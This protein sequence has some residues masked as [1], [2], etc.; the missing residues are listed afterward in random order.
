MDYFKSIRPY[1]DSEVSE[2]LDQF[3]THDLMQAM[4]LY[5][6]PELTVQERMEKLLA[7]QS[8]VDFQTKIMYQ[9]VKKAIG[10]TMQDFTTDGFEHLRPEKS[11]LFISNHR[12]II[13]DTS[14]LNVALHDHH[15]RMTASA[16]GD[17]L[18]RKKFL[19]ALAMLNRNFIIHRGLPLRES[20]ERSGIV[21]EYIYY[22][23]TQN[24]RSVWIAQR[25]GRT[26]NGDDRT[27]QGVL[28]M[29]TLATPSG[30]TPLQYL[31]KLSVVPMAVSYEFDPTDMMKMPAIMAQHYGVE[32]IKSKKE[33]FENIIQGLVGQKGRVHVSV[34]KPLDEELDAIE[35]ENAHINKQLQAV[36]ELLDERIHKQFRL[37]PTNY[38][39]YDMLN[40]TALHADQYSEKELR[41]FERRLSNRNKSGDEISKEKFL[42]MYANPVK[43]KMK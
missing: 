35:S 31:K 7:C 15:L 10:R 1:H 19:K 24:N 26:K 33:D 6:F 12:D 37:F 39:A 20:L 16:I 36:A 22:S 21:S 28:K 2:V 4:L 8:V 32:Y 23:I 34:S 38:I 27:Q 43:N 14:L 13:L 3:K 9:V 5:G 18:V 29:L 41:Q 17:N 40:Q 30:I 11:Y 25:E 42:E